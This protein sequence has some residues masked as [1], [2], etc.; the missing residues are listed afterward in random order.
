MRQIS[1]YTIP[2]KGGYA[3]VVKKG[4]QL[5]ITN[6]EGTQVVDMAVFNADNPREKLSP[7][8]SRTRYEP[9]DPT[10]YVPRDRLTVG[11]K[12][13]VDQVPAIDDHRRR[14]RR[15]QRRAQYPQPHVLPLHVQSFWHGEGR[16]RRD[17]S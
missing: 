5:R 4:Q 11:G 13:D 16:L 17:H 1:E 6:I 2:P 9:V 10:K 14:N 8:W 15:T 7:S 12:P 3:V